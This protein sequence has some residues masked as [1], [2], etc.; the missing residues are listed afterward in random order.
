M[1]NVKRLFVEKKPGF[2]I[3]AGHMLADLK[4]NLGIKTIGLSVLSTDTTLRA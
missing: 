1:S 2:D 4:D 3:E